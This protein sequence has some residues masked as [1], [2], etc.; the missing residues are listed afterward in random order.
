MTYIRVK[1]RKNFFRTLRDRS[2]PDG[3]DEAYADVDRLRPSSP[4]RGPTTEDD[5]NRT[6]ADDL[7]DIVSVTASSAASYPFM[8]QFDVR[9][10]LYYFLRTHQ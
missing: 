4:L 2:G 6:I 5:L 3:S 1:E 7:D 8:R 10:V 9:V